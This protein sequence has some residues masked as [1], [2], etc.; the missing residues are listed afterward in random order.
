MKVGC[1]GP[2][3]SY[4]CVA[5]KILS[6]EAEVTPYINFPAVVKALET[7]EADE[8]VL[9]I[10]NTIQG[11]VVQ[12]MDLLAAAE[13]LVAVKEYALPIEHR[14]VTKAGVSFSQV[15]R[16]YSHP[17][18]IG[19][20]AA[21]LSKNLPNA[22]PMP[23]NSTADG[24]AMLKEKEDACIIGAHLAKSLDTQKYF[25]YPENIADEKRDF[26]HFVLVKKGI[27][28][29][30]QTSSRVYFVAEL[31]HRPGSLYQLLER[32]NRHGLN[33]TKIESRPVKDRLGE[34]R[35]FIEIE[36]DY[37]SERVKEALKDLRENCGRLKVLGCY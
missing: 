26:T 15:K 4:S 33:M 35:F 19:Q 24:L 1:L 28:H 12:N 2:E 23:A 31:A 13:G 32:I 10:E 18:A 6:P 9:P 27:E 14:F 34:Y 20:C 30:Q 16:V 25:V 11:G 8:I 21:F 36:G 17:Q 22:I 7:G 37:L 5:A 29:L 3:G